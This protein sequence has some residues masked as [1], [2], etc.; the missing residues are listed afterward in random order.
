MFAVR[1]LH[2]DDSTESARAVLLRD[3]EPMDYYVG[4]STVSSNTASTNRSDYYGPNSGSEQHYSHLEAPGHGS[5]ALYQGGAGGDNFVL[6]TGGM[7]VGLPSSRGRVGPP[8]R[9]LFDDV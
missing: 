1:P 7:F 3:V 6:E 8:P 2:R 9:G 5:T 4:E